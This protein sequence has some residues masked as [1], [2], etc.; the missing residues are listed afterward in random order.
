MITEMN[1]DEM[2]EVEGGVGAA[3][4]V[5]LVVVGWALAAAADYLDGGLND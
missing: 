3:V 1:Q 2:M 4:I 5:A